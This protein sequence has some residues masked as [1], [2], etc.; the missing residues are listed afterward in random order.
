ME[1]AH[2][3][4]QWYLDNADALQQVLLREPVEPTPQQAHSRGG[5]AS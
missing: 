5:H 4:R 3:T 1:R 2:N